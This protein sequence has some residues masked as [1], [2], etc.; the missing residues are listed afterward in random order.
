MRKPHWEEESQDFTLICLIPKTYP[1]IQWFSTLAIWGA[2]KTLIPRPL[3]QVNGME[4]K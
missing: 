2:S 1:L 4:W 3:L